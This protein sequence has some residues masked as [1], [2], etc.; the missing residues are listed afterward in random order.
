MMSM[1]CDPPSAADNVPVDPAD[2]F[3]YPDEDN[4]SWYDKSEPAANNE[5]SDIEDEDPF[6]FVMIDGDTDA[7]DQSLVDQWSFLDD[8]GGALHSK[9]SSTEHNL[10]GSRN[11]TFD[12]VEEKYQIKCNSLLRNDTSCHSIFS[13]GASNTIAKMPSNVGASGPYARV[14][15]LTPQGSTTKRS[16]VLPRSADQVYDMKV[17][18]DLGA[19]ASESKGDVNF[20]VDYTNLQEYWDKVTDSPAKHKKRWFGD[21]DTWLE[22]ETSIVQD[23]K[24]YLPLTYEGD[25]KLLELTQNCSGDSP[26]KLDLDVNMKVGLHAQYA[27]Y[28][29]GAILPTPKLIAAYSYFSVEPSADILFQLSREATFQSTTGEADLIE[30][31]PFSGMSIKGLIDIGPALA[32]TG[33]IDISLTFAGELQAGVSAN[34]KKTEIYFPQDLA[35]QD[36]TVKPSGIKP[37]LDQDDEPEYLITPEFEASATASG[38]INF[39]LT[40]KVRFGISVLGGKLSGGFVT[41]G[42]ENTISVGFDSSSTTG[43]CYWA[44]YLYS[45]FVQAEVKFPGDLTYW[46]SDKFDLASPD[47]PITL[48]DKS[49]VPWEKKV[50]ITPRDDTP[51]DADLGENYDSFVAG[52][53]AGAPDTKNDGEPIFSALLACPGKNDTIPDDAY[54]CSSQSSFKRAVSGCSLPPALFYNCDYFPDLVVN[55]NNQNTNQNNPT[56]T[57]TGICKNVKNYLDGHQNDPGVGSNYMLLTY[58][59]GSNNPANTNRNQACDRPGGPGDQCKELKKSLWPQAVQ[60]AVN[61]DKNLIRAKTMHGW[62]DNMSCDEFPCE[63]PLKRERE[64]NNLY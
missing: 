21:F 5:A 38:H 57:L 45:L 4:V 24:G 13:G 22:K 59:K 6:A 15:S 35:G 49:C 19:A 56:Q 58:W 16:N 12:N 60:D 47:D 9:R 44:D 18:Y 62:T 64:E 23:E 37:Y 3:E 27:Y 55:N 50:T 33:S 54:S 48:I 7:Y 31:I 8:N 29:E 25:A 26:Y 53:I 32:I 40:P 52:D 11:D 61:K 17:D 10:F 41:A 63:L 28:F 1:C 46:G 2:L 51:G 39:N 30:D 36:A 34:W 43:F 42:V 20:R 14:I